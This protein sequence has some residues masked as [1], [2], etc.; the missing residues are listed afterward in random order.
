MVATSVRYRTQDPG[1]D[2]VSTISLDV[3]CKRPD[4]LRVVKR[5]T[6]SDGDYSPPRRPPVPPEASALTRR[7][8]ALGGGT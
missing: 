5:G 7:D 4:F 3:G 6:N 1:G 8:I 2:A